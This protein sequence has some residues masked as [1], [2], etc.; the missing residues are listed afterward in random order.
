[1][2]SSTSAVQLETHRGI[3][4]D[5]IL[6]L[7][8]EPAQTS[9]AGFNILSTNYSF[10]SPL[11]EVDRK[12][13]AQFVF[14]AF[15]YTLPVLFEL[16]SSTDQQKLALKIEVD[17]GVILVWQS[18]S[19]PTFNGDR[20]FF[21]EAPV[22]IHVTS[23]KPRAHFIAAS[24]QSLLLLDPSATLQVPELEFHAT[25]YFTEPLALVSKFLRRRQLTYR[26][27]VIE[28]AFDQELA[29]PSH[30][31][32][33]DRSNIEFVYYSVAER[34]FLWPF[35]QD[36]FDFP[37]NE[38]VRALLDKLDGT[39]P[40]L[41]E[42]GSLQEAVLGQYLNLGPVNITVQNT[43][44]VAPEEVQRE[45]Q[46]LDGHVFRVGIKSLNGAAHYEFTEARHL[47]NSP[48]DERIEQLIKLED[49]LD[50]LYFE[51]VNQLAAASLA[52]LTE[53]EK[54]ALTE[55]FTLGEEAFTD[56]ETEE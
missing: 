13:S 47:P 55:S 27:M 7:V 19:Q 50:D 28:K 24:L 11:P 51:S 30:V 25:L 54:A 14:P 20:A 16:T 31:S 10:T 46:R 49:Q 12:I 17:E 8:P 21:K 15:N 56:S 43:A 40:F 1:M 22:G 42:I 29:I 23:S 38:Q 45:L 18:S 48:W 3:L 53:E 2:T 33:T 37:A 35:G 9:L 41:I 5:T 52:G 39:Y 36:F 6:A 26:T 44:L 34:S 32:E 4:A